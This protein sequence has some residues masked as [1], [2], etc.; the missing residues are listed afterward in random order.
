MP[1]ST[2]ATKT[3]R[4]LVVGNEPTPYN[5]DL[6][7]ALSALPSW[8]TTVFYPQAK[9]WEKDAGHDFRLMPEWHYEGVLSTGKGIG[10]QLASA[11]RLV[12]LLV[13]DRPDKVLVSGYGSLAHVSAI[14]LFSLTG[15]P[16]AFWVDQ[17]N[18]GKPR[19]GAWPARI[20]RDAIRRVVFERAKAVLVCG[21]PG[22]DSAMLAGCD[23]SKLVDFPYVVDGRRMR[24]L[25]ESCTG[26]EGFDPAP[27]RG[28]LVVFSGR[29]I[30]RKGLDVLLDALL[31]LRKRETEFFLVVEGDGPLR[32]QHVARVAD[33]GLADRV[34]FAGFRQM[35]E[36]S[37]LL[38]VAD[39]VVVPS[40]QDPWGLVVHEGMLMGKP[41]CASDAVGSAMDRIDPGQNGF[42]F[43]SGDAEALS[44][45]LQGLLESA[46]LRQ[47]MGEAA[48]R[49]A[50]LRSPERNAR[51]LMSSL[52]EA[53][54]S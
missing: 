22:H 44:A 11:L 27:H 3:H 54:S 24:A 32:S 46:E 37:Y 51:A 8:R 52:L 31:L 40:T 12:T 15:T 18:V 6:F 48:Q 1:A 50:E 29:L 2:P 14:L 34:W 4:L 23:E 16:F 28:R 35:N 36:H 47:R 26:I 30:E 7:N 21:R 25:A 5:T 45:R 43:P 33:A 19:R 49:S 10:G 9:N 42:I 38:S 53:S 20:V 41:V 39:V 17:F 13:R